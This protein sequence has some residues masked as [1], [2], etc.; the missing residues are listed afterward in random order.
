MAFATVDWI[1]RGGA[2]PDIPE[3]TKALTVTTYTFKGEQLLVE[4]KE[5]IKDKLGFSPDHLDALMLTFAYPVERDPDKGSL[6]KTL[7]IKNQGH[8][9]DYDPLSRNYIIG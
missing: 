6:I 7:P 5:D 3:L 8:Q 9:F 4:P 1:K 2:L